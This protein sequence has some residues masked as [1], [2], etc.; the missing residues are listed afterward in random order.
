MAYVFRLE[1]ADGSPAE[2]PSFRTSEGNWVVGDVVP[3]GRRRLRVVEIRDDDGDQP[4]LFVV[5]EV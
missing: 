1:N 5:E 2:P 3:M 4:P